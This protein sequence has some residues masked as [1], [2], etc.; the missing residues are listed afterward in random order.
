MINDKFFKVLLLIAIIINLALSVIFK[1]SNYNQNKKLINA[2]LNRANE[3]LSE[4]VAQVLSYTRNVISTNTLS[5]ITTSS[6]QFSSNN[7]FQSDT[8]ILHKEVLNFR[9]HYFEVDNKPF[10]KIGLINLSIGQPFPRGG[11]ITAI[12]PDCIIL[13]NRGL[14]I[15]SNYSDET[16]LSRVNTAQA[17]EINS[18]IS[19]T[20]TEKDNQLRS[21]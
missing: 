10:A 15:N 21:L 20:L 19:E 6:N 18:R 4:M 12:Y 2:N 13:D 5:N 1:I 16:L 7:I 3:Q 14:V 17:S 9:Y 8:P 11:I